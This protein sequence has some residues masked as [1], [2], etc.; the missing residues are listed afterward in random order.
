MVVL[1]QPKEDKVKEALK[2]QAKFFRRPPVT[3][4]MRLSKWLE[5]LILLQKTPNRNSRDRNEFLNQY[6]LP[7]NGI[8]Y[9][10]IGRNF[11]K[12][13]LIIFRQ[14]KGDYCDGWTKHRKLQLNFRYIHPLS[15]MT[16]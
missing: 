7:N 8:G 14:D 3:Y 4:P 16:F 6:K 12:F 10:E 13:F 15:K 1:E 2:Q 11:E 5:E 9:P